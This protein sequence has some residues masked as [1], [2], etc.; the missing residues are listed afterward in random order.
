MQSIPYEIVHMIYDYLLRPADIIN[1]AL[2]CRYLHHNISKEHLRVLSIRRKYQDINKSIL[3]IRYYIST[4]IHRFAKR[5]IRIGTN[6]VTI[7]A[8]ANMGADECYY[9]GRRT[10][11]FVFVI[12]GDHLIDDL[13]TVRPGL[14]LI[15]EHFTHDEVEI[16]SILGKRN[17]RTERCY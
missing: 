4:P 15:K 3:N 10:F 14:L 13:F 17:I 12:Y 6:A 1:L 5:S 11:R 2:T 8:N 7:Y 9:D 16:I